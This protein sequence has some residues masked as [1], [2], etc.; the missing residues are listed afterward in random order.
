M[1]FNTDA[2]RWRAEGAET[3]A[4]LRDRMMAALRDI[5]AAHSN[6]TVALFSHGM[7]L[8]LLV[9]TLN[10]LTI[11]EVDKSGHGENTSVTKLEADENGIRV[12]Y[13]TDASHLPEA[14]TTLHKQL[15]TKTKGGLEPGIWFA[16]AGEHCFD[17]M[18]DDERVGAVA[19]ERRGDGVMAVTKFT[20][21]EIARGRNLGIRLVGQAVSHARALGCD[22]LCVEG[23]A[24]HDGVRVPRGGGNAAGRGAGKILR[25]GRGVPRRAIRSGVRTNKNVRKEA[26]SGLFLLFAQR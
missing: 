11:A 26:Q 21:D 7:A 18:Q 10:G 22:T 2:G 6:Q 14:L 13:A 16:P 1:N 5:I 9:G 20:L 19:V 25:Q 12:V 4:Q 24:P 8:R 23:A 15:W 17:V 3:M